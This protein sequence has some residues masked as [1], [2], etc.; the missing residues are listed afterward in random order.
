M[1]STIYK[2]I[3]VAV[4][5]TSAHAKPSNLWTGKIYL[6]DCLK[7]KHQRKNST[8]EIGGVT[9]GTKAKDACELM[10]TNS[11]N[12]RKKDIQ[13]KIQQLRDLEDAKKQIAKYIVEVKKQQ[14][15]DRTKIN[16]FKKILKVL[17]KAND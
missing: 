10:L 13:T 16:E 2:I 9:L 5:A 1:L 11:I 14:V 12:A 7:L 8:I 4:L 6:E 15:E 17:A 3:L